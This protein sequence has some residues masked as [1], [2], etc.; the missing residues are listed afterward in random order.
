MSSNRRAVEQS[1]T[2]RLKELFGPVRAETFVG[3]THTR[4]FTDNLLPTF[5]GWQV[6]EL[7]QQLKAGG[8]S[9]L[10]ANV[11]GKRRA[12][13][14]Y[15]S[16]AGA[17]NLFGRWLGCEQQLE[18]A[19]VSGL[20][21]RLRVESKHRIVKGGG[22]ANLDVLLRGPDATVGVECKLAEHSDVH[23]PVEWKAPYKAPEMA[24]L[25]DDKWRKVMADSIAGS[26]QP[27]RLGIEQLVKHVLGLVSQ[28]P[29]RQVHLVY[30]YWEP[31]NADEHQWV[32][33]HRVEVDR[34]RGY[35]DGSQIPLHAMTYWQLLDE[36]AELD[37]QPEWLAEHLTAIGVRYR[38]DVP[39]LPK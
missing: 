10:T 39:A 7:Y 34:L 22:T 3:G 17:F 1:L 8:G 12:H 6:D 23:D 35:V 37:P 25:L 27:Q 2:A 28:H 16:A 20:P 9:E 5:P 32:L 19:G 29:N 33:D 4:R 30:V 13:A 11:N 15:S 14:P 24:G 26:W 31:A 18:I 38:V 21:E 36:W